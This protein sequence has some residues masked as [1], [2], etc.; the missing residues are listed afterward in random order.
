L[1]LLVLQ[2]A[3]LVVKDRKVFTWVAAGAAAVVIF[4]SPLTWSA[5]FSDHLPMP[6]ASYLSPESGSWFPLFP[7]A[8][9][10]LCG[11]VAGSVVANFGKPGDPGLMF[12][13]G[14][15]SLATLL[16]A[17]AAMYL[18]FEVYP[19]HDFWKS[20][21]TMFFVR[22]GAIGVVASC[23]FMIGHVLHWSKDPPRIAS[24][25]GRESLFIYILH[26]VIVYGS[27]V[28]RGLAQRVGPTL[29]LFE[30]TTAFAFVFVLIASIAVLWHK[31]K[32]NYESAASM[33]AAAGAVTF[34]AVFVVRPW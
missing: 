9:Y 8:A 6:I 26:L 28:N 21:P 23:I 33:A 14:V 4:I 10:L 7:W 24:I 31:L 29:S 20:N 5:R 17:W 32:T 30:A 13:G 27:V 16:L 25:I 3:V 15:L 12:K 2:I 11:A 34:L 18:P 19:V 1:T 22:L